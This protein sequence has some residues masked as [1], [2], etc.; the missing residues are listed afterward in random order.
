MSATT[1]PSALLLAR[2]AVALSIWTAASAFAQDRCCDC[3]DCCARMTLM[4]WSY[5]TSFEGGPDLDEPLVTDRPDFTEA[6]TTVGLGVAQVEMG[7]TFIEDEEGGTRVTSHS[8]PE[9]LLRVGILANWLEL[10]VGWNYGDQ[11]TRT[12]GSSSNLSGSDDLLLGFKIGLTPQE[13]VLP[14]MALIPEFTVPVGSAGFSSG[15]V[16]P[17]MIWIYGWDLE[18]VSLAGSSAIRR[19][20]DDV[21]GDPFGEYAQSFVMG[22]DLTD[23]IGSYAEWFVFVPAG[24]ET[25]GTQHFFNGGFTFLVNNDLQLDV[26]AGVGLSDASDDYFVGSGFAKRF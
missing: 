16:L 22:K 3:S 10:R 13:G 12:S 20:L 15:E 5:G 18:C 14:E 23:R 25:V 24:A 26:R 6:T 19:A 2:F 11:R 4:Q 7:Y 21:T 9:S 17:G 1:R 8:Y